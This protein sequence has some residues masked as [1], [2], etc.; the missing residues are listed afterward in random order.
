LDPLQFYPELSNQSRQLHIPFVSAAIHQAA[1][2]W[3]P[4]AHYR[5]NASEVDT[6]SKHFRLLFALN[7]LFDGA[8][9]DAPWKIDFPFMQDF[10][11]PKELPWL[12]F[13]SEG[14]TCGKR[15]HHQNH[16]GLVQTHFN[17][18]S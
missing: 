4:Y 15:E 7:D 18:R 5:E 17:R 6:R 1:R 9:V 11:A 13:G 14:S 2:G 10:V 8:I 3:F 16:H 12:G